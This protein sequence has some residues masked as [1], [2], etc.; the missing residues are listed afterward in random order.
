MRAVEL[1]AGADEEIAA[2]LTHVD[3]SVGSVVNRVDPEPGAH[4][5][6]DRGNGLQV[7]D[8]AHGVGGVGDRHQP[9]T[10]RDLAFQVLEVQGAVVDPDVREAH[11]DSLRLE[12]Q[13]GGHV[14]IMLEPGDH[15][16][17]TGAQLR[18]NR[19]A[20]G[21]GKGGHVGPEDDLVRRSVEEGRGGLARPLDHGVAALAGLEQAAV[22]G[23]HR[24]PVI[25]DPLHDPPRHLG[26]GGVVEVDDRSSVAGQAEGRELST[27]R[28]KIDAGSL[29]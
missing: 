22:V 9:R 16:L 25:A 13:P 24:R 29:D 21:K 11:A 10:R 19:P 2:H 1:V 27:Q 4:P 5:V 20:H 7:G 18:S 26:A 15:D 6:G 23:V 3:R 17:V 28:R 12:R 8:G 14:G